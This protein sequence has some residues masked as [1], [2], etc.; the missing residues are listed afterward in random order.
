[1]MQAVE[2]SCVNFDGEK[3]Q[4]EEKMIYVLWGMMKSDFAQFND[5]PN[6]FSESIAVIH[7]V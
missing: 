3:G 7:T 1:M 2:T 6:C 4:Q 5:H